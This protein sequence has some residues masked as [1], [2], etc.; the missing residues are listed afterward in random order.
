MKNVILI[1]PVSER[2]KWIT[3]F[4]KIMPVWEIQSLEG[5]QNKDLIDTALVWDHPRGV[6]KKFKNINLICSLGAGVDHL[7]SDT[8]IPNGVRITRIVDPL[9]SFSMSN[10]IIM[11]VLQYHRKFDKYLEDQKNKNWDHDL[12]PEI[13]IV[14]GVLGIG[15]LGGDAAVK[16][17]NLGFKVYGYSP[18]AK[19]IDGIRCFSGDEMNEFLKN[20]NVLI[21]TVPYT[22]KTHNLLS[23]KFFNQLKNPTYLI[24]VARGKVQNEED[25]I[26]AIDKGI[27]TGAFLDVFEKEP[28][29]T[30]SPLWGNKKIKI[31]PHIASI[32]NAEAGANQIIENYNRNKKGESLCNEVDIKKGY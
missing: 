29:P 14:I 23:S 17:K 30:S 32:T 21:C 26:N 4:K 20:I 18:S 15:T 13:S 12:K 8:E 31:T 24:N 11:A 25:I 7:I 2:K 16:L 6:L 19:K 28:L 1:T 3:I 10:Y 27:L 9:L 22:Q 5:V